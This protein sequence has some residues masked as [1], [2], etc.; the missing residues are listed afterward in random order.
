M[1]QEVSSPSK[2]SWRKDIGQDSCCLDS[3][4]QTKFEK[5]FGWLLKCFQIRMDKKSKSPEGD[6]S[7]NSITL[8]TSNGESIVEL[9]EINEWNEKCEEKGCRMG[10]LALIQRCFF[11]RL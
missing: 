9:I 2:D 10:F 11:G 5:V 7:R 4:Q 3:L 6:M 1:R 8:P